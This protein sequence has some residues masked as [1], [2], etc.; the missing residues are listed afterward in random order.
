MVTLG[1]SPMDGMWRTYQKHAIPH[2]CY[3]AKLGRSNGTS[4][5]RDPHENIGPSHPSFQGHSRSRRVSLN[6]DETNTDQSATYYFLLVIA[7]IWAYSRTVSEISLPM[8]LCSRVR[9][10]VRD[11]QTDRRQTK[12]SLNVS[13]NK[14]VNVTATSGSAASDVLH[15]CDLNDL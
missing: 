8:P 10:D 5:R 3:Y 13:G 2:K 6:H 1:P 9:P 15:H 11:R 12:A 14:Q 4:T 7:T